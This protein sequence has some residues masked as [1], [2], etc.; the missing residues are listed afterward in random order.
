MTF[1]AVNLPD[2]LHLDASS[3]IITGVN[4]PRGEYV[5]ALARKMTSASPRSCSRSSV[6]TPSR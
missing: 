2:S 3:G 6:A 4:P 5:V 1:A